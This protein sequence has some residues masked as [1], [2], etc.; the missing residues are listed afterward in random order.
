MNKKFCFALTSFVLSVVGLFSIL[1]LT[2]SILYFPG[3]SYNYS[4]LSTY[5]E[6]SNYPIHTLLWIMLSGLSLVAMIS[7]LFVIMYTLDKKEIEHKE[8]TIC[9]LK[10]KWL[11]VLLSVYLL[12][13][14]VIVI[15]SWSIDGFTFSHNYVLR[16]VFDALVHMV[17]PI[18]CGVV[19]LACIVSFYVYIL[20]FRNKKLKEIM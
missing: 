12:V 19:N 15:L 20:K 18:V 4:I 2:N 16:N 13:I 11:I 10:K 9:L 14:L 8:A 6:L 5:I 3:S 7:L 17:M 1:C